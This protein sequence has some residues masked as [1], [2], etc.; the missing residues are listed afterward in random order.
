L[1]T[2]NTVVAF[3][4]KHPDSLIRISDRLTVQILTQL[5]ASSG[6]SAEAH[7]SIRRG[8]W[9]GGEQAKAQIV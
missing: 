7:K 1:C 4:Q 6:I 5:I 2:L 3:A 8:E 9:E